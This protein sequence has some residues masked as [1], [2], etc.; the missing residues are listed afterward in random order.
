M[1]LAFQFLK[2]YSCYFCFAISKFYYSLKAT[3]NNLMAGLAL[4]SFI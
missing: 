3:I 1:G 4:V 2:S